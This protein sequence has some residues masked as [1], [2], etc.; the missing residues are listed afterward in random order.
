MQAKLQGIQVFGVS[1][2]A[3]EDLLRGAG[4]ITQ[5]QVGHFSEASSVQNYYA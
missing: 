2:F 1:H 3:G 4:G 5:V